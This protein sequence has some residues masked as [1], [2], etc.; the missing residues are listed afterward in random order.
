MEL[1]HSILEIVKNTIAKLDYVVNGKC[2]YTTEVNGTKYQFP[3]NT[4]EIG[5][6]KEYWTAEYKSI[7]LMR[8][9]REAKEKGELIQL[10]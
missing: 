2:I 4:N 7:T 6:E 9:I 10:N 8:W 3:V 1:K 5:N